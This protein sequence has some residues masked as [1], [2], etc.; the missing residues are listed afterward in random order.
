[1]IALLFFSVLLFCTEIIRL[2]YDIE[3][4]VL[5]ETTT[6]LNT[7]PN[8]STVT[9]SGGG[10]AVL[11]N[12]SDVLIA[13]CDEFLPRYVFALFEFLYAN[14]TVSPNR[15]LCYREKNFLN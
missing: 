4:E 11:I 8:Y 13:E 3:T 1:M 10:G 14:T 7:L 6:S 15:Y 2:D 5:R 9:E 12:N